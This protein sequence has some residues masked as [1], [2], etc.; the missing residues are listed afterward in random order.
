MELFSLLDKRIMSICI[1][2]LFVSLR[3]QLSYCWRQI[4]YALSNR[5]NWEDKR[6]ARSGERNSCRN[7]CTRRVTRRRIGLFQRNWKWRRDTITW[8][9]RASCVL[10]LLGLSMAQP[11]HWPELWKRA[12]SS[13]WLLILH[14]ELRRTLSRAW[15][16]PQLYKYL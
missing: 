16:P 14:W 3:E 8:A 10:L 2:I 4:Y 15:A 5:I 12:M 7:I 6:K 9:L 11:L 1:Y 13:L